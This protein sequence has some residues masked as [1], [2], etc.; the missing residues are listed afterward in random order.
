MKNERE[1]KTERRVWR[2]QGNI[3][4]NFNEITLVI[5]QQCRDS[6]NLTH[7]DELIPACIRIN[8]KL[9][10]LQHLLNHIID[11]ITNNVNGAVVHVGGSRHDAVLLINAH[12]RRFALHV[13]GTHHLRSSARIS[14]GVF[15]AHLLLS[16]CDTYTR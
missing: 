1:C 6:Q 3:I 4:Y 10:Q 8:T 12:L 11:S 9:H 5:T 7:C 14:E 2:K 16:Q 13:I 15:L